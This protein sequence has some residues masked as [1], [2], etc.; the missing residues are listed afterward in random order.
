M[1]IPQKRKVGGVES[2]ID[3]ATSYPVS[4]FTVLLAT[5]IGYWLIS[6]VL[7]LGDFGLD[8]DI[9]IDADG[10][11]EVEAGPASDGFAIE[12]DGFD[13]S[14]DG[15]SFATNL[16]II[17][18]IGVAP[19]NI[20]ISIFSLAAWTMAMLAMT[21]FGSLPL[22]PA[23]FVL[24][25]GVIVGLAVSGRV[26][27]LLRP[28]FVAQTATKHEQLIGRIVTIRT[29]RV[30]ATF[31]QGEIDGP[32]NEDHIAQIRCHE[33]NDY[34]TGDRALVVAVDDG[35]IFTIS[36]DKNIIKTIG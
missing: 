21:T 13:G 17:T 9:G 26:A 32:G 12:G 36:S 14:S 4:I 10:G 2:F 18:G 5:S 35:G 28:L 19:F 7:G 27:R 3:T 1:F 31:G 30:D 6:T 20:V 22:L 15:P 23:T 24:I 11:F 33:K 29:G 8:S 34:T 25:V 16:A